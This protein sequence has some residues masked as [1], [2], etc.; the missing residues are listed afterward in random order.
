LRVC[1]RNGQ[2]QEIGILRQLDHWDRASQE[3]VRSAISRRYLFRRILGIEEVALINHNLHFH[4]RTDQGPAR[5]VMRWIQDQ[6]QD[7]GRRGKILSDL[8]DNRYLVEDLDRLPRRERE[9]LER[10]IY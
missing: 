7:F 3:L 8:N 10:F 4:V 6:A 5:F 2:E 1:N 9:R